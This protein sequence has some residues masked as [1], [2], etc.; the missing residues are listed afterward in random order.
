MFIDLPILNDPRKR[1]TNSSLVLVF[2]F[3]CTLTFSQEK[4]TLSGYISDFENDESL[5]GVSVIIPKL[6]IGT[7]TNEYGFFSLTLPRGNYT[8]QISYLGFETL[9]REM[10]LNKDVTENFTL[11]PQTEQLEE[12]IVEE[13]Y[14]ITQCEQSSNECQYP[15]DQYDQKKFLLYSER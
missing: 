5:I 15:I 9:V 3:F 6:K 14:R 12:V 11:N 13:K 2:I 7:I 1:K 8:F 10:T 4:V